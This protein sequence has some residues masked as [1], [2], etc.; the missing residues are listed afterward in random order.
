MTTYYTALT[1]KA[2]F[3]ALDTTHP[4]RDSVP[5]RT[6]T[7]WG[8]AQYAYRYMRGVTFY[9][10]AGHGGF[11]V[12]EKLN[13]TMPAHLRIDDGWYEEDCDWSKVALAFP[14]LFSA[15]EVAE[16]S[17]SLASF[18]PTKWEAHFGRALLPG[19][20]SAKDEVAFKAAHANDYVVISALNVGDGKV[21][22]C[23]TRGGDRNS[24]DQKWF[25]VTSADY[26]ARTR[27]GFV[28][29][30]TTDLE[31]TPGFHGGK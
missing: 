1:P 17:S 7:P 4:V 10:T 25:V 5:S 31:T 21:K 20:S 6:S 23:A 14:A 11:K 26:D 24:D 13:A 28:V 3:E 9:G 30:L 22:V 8:T 16:A 18:E 12:S 29:N 27:F 2:D 19:E 15:H